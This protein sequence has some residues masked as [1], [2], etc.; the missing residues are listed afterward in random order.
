MNA[1]QTIFFQLGVAL[2]I[3]LLIG[4]ERGWQRREARE[5]QRIAGVRTYG[6]TGLL[7]G[8]SA[9]LA[10]LVGPYVIGLVFIGMVGV[11]TA[12]Y[13]ANLRQGEGTDVSITGVVAALL[14][15]ILGA[16]AVSGM[17]EIAVAVGVVALL[18]L[19]YKPLLHRWVNALEESELRAASKLLLI[20]AVV[21][22]LLPDRGLAVAG[23]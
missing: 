5:G 17:E 12:V 20:S 22:P 23:A 10:G 8:C 18:L 19:E 13:I 6:L 2:A 16:L 3:G 14:V 4:V 15:F 7:G 9:L 21:L 11:F 1:E